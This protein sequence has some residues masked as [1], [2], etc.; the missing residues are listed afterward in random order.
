MNEPEFWEM[1][2]KP[3]DVE[4]KKLRKNAKPLL[5]LGTFTIEARYA[6]A[7][8]ME[9]LGRWLEYGTLMDQVEDALESNAE[10]E[11]PRS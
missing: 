5:E 8:D 11:E 6:T 3:S 9:E 7:K 4:M 10:E 2:I 1:V